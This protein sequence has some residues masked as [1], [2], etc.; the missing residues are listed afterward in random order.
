MANAAVCSFIFLHSRVCYSCLFMLPFSSLCS[1]CV[2][3]DVLDFSVNAAVMFSLSCSC[4]CLCLPVD[5]A[6]VSF[7]YI[8]SSVNNCSAIFMELSPYYIYFCL[9]GCAYAAALCFHPCSCFVYYGV[10]ASVF[11]CFYVSAAVK[12]SLFLNVS[13]CFVFIP[14]IQ[15]SSRIHVS[16]NG[17]MYSGVPTTFSYMLVLCS[18]FRVHRYLY[19]HILV[20]MQLFYAFW[21]P[22]SCCV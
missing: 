6:V 3:A 11:T 5:E 1:S 10:Y 16:T 2:D 9:Y 13:Q 17:F 15:P 18:C 14:V 20:F 7:L 8:S 12:M 22:C 19:N 4:S 21:C